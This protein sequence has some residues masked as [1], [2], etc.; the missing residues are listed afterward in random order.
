[1]KTKPKT[2]LER[3]RIDLTNRQ[4]ARIYS[5]LTEEMRGRGN[6]I[7]AFDF[8]P[9]HKDMAVTILARDFGDKLAKIIGKEWRK[10][11]NRQ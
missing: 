7:C 3:F 11:C 9:G 5:F 8:K 4:V 10:P 2:I 6:Y 1:M